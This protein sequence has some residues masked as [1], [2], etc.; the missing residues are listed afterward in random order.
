M[1]SRGES[2]GRKDVGRRQL[3]KSSLYVSDS[4]KSDGSYRNSV[5]FRTVAIA[6]ATAMAASK[7][8]SAAF[9]SETVKIRIS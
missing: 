8:S 9:V 4:G 2:G 5:Y 6:I 3:A 1:E 7:Y